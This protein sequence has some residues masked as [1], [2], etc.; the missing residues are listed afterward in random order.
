M[1]PGWAP[2]PDGIE[3]RRRPEKYGAP[4]RN[5]GTADRRV[6]EGDARRHLDSFPW[7]LSVSCTLRPAWR[8]ARALSL[9]VVVLQLLGAPRPIAP[10][11]ARFV[12]ASNSIL[13]RGALACRIGSASSTRIVALRGVTFELSGRHRRGGLAARRMTSM[14]ASRPRRLAGGGPLERRVRARSQHRRR[15]WLRRTR[16]CV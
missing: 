12:H 10:Y 15:S 9:A 16:Q 7:R 6:N 2:A 1:E 4:S 14:G 11:V 3:N 13:R 8:F 5:T